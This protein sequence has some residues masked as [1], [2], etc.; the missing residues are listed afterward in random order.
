[1]GPQNKEK[2]RYEECLYLKRERERERERER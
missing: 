2:E 1:M